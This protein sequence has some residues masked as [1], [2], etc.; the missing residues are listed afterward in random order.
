[1][2][3]LW[4]KEVRMEIFLVGGAV[5]DQLLGL[6]S[7]DMDWV[8]V[9]AKPDDLISKGYKV[10]GAAF[11]VFIHPE[12]GD[13]YALARKE[14]KT[15]LKHNDFET[16][17]DPSVTLEDD[18]SRRDLTINAI[19]MSKDGKLIDPYG[20]AKDLKNRL[21]RHVSGAFSEDPLRILRV[22]RFMARFHHLGFKVDASTMDLMR[23]IGKE[24]VHISE[25]RIWKELSRALTEKTPSAFIST[26]KDCDC[27]K[28][29]LPEVDALFGVPQPE[30]HHPEIDTGIHT[31]MV[32]EQARK[33]TNDVD[34]IFSAMTH[35]LG[36]ALTKKE[37]LPAHH[38]HDEDG[39]PV[40]EMLCKRLKVPSNTKK[41]AVA[42]CKNHTTVHRAFELRPGTIVKLFNQID[43]YRD[44]GIL[45]KLLTV[46]E[47]DAKGRIGFEN[48]KYNQS[49]LL[50]NAFKASLGVTAKEFVEKG[51]SGEKI[52][53]QINAKRIKVVKHEIYS[54]GLEP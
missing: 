37:M 45:D 27:L 2:P 38:N 54:S 20:G 28:Y 25:E 8:V 23:G 36:K 1:M 30:K 51:Y 18:L 11:P 48:I 5:R 31:L 49:E 40:V 22:A 52:R 46:C 34:I 41:L 3:F 13:E 42:A 6:K 7:K 15:G 53:E 9:G 44:R 17:F 16:F 10:A 32:M 43:A 14:R 19:A 33:L 4:H 12:T 21:I 26:L 47:S 39:V 24:L 50:K 35:D 29:V